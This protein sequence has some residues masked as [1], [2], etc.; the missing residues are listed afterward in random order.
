VRAAVVGHVEWVDF[1]RVDHVPESGEIV[2]ASEGWSQPGGGG[3]NAAAQLVKLAGDCSFF[4]ALGD[5]DLGRRMFERLAALGIAVH[6]TFRAEPTRRAITHVD[7]QGERTITVIGARLEP[8]G[9][10]DL[11]W[12]ELARAD[13]VYFTAGDRAALEAARRA[14]VL[15]GTSRVLDTFQGVRLDA[16]VSSAADVSERYVAGDLDPAPDLVVRTE[17]GK[18]GTFET[19]GVVA[20]YDAAALPGP[21]VDRYGAGDSFAAG[22]AF[23]LAEGRSVPEAIAFAARCGAWVITGRGPFEAQLKL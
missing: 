13:C 18:G 17:G 15:V 19:G 2:H 23:S 4:T 12:S 3:A 14:R 16:L 11:P 6:A 5:D 20:S 8:D 7:A 10:D 9:N 22:L 21:I 1:V